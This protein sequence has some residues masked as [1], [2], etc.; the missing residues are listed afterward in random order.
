MEV[1]RSI[2]LSNKFG[3][4]ARASTRLAQTAKQF[5]ASIR[6][7]RQGSDED[8]DA[9]SILGILTLGAEKGQVLSIRTFGEDAEQAMVAVM[10]L[11]QQNFGEE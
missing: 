1:V 3:L 6:V 5:Q 7:S 9:K 2:E 11:I 10:Q 8:V 4:H